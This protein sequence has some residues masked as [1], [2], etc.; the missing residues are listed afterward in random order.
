MK[1]LPVWSVLAVGVLLARAAGVSAEDGRPAGGPTREDA[2]K[3]AKTIAG[4]VHGAL[5][6]AELLDELTRTRGDLTLKSAGRRAVPEKTFFGVEFLVPDVEFEDFVTNKVFGGEVPGRRVE[7]KI[8]LDCDVECRVDVG[9]IKIARHEDY[10]DTILVILPKPELIG[11]V[12]EGREYRYQ[13][14]YGWLRAKWLDSDEARSVRKEMVSRAARKAG[15][16][17]SKSEALVEFRKGLKREL[18]AFLKTTLPEG[19]RIEIRFGD[20]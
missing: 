15:E 4:R 10:E 5:M 3:Q 12:P 9:N 20:E 18:R 13:V 8:W 14:D 11:R 6:L 7:V 2:L 16:E 19:R 17:F 1:F